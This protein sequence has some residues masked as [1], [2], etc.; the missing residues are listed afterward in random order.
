MASKGELEQKIIAITLSNLAKS[1]QEHTIPNLRQ[2]LHEHIDEDVYQMYEPKAYVRRGTS[3]GLLDDNNVKTSM[4]VNP[5]DKS[6][7]IKIRNEA[8]PINHTEQQTFCG[9]SPTPLAAII[10]YG[11]SKDINAPDYARPRPFMDNFYNDLSVHDKALLKSMV[12]EAIV[13]M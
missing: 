13:N 4:V 2:R 11:M 3:N 7:L 8:L 9:S 5:G 12:L 6:I 10:N 1:L